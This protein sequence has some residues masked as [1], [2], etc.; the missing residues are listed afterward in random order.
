MPVY[1]GEKYLTGAIESI[2]RQSFSDFEFIIVNDGSTDTT[3]A[4][5]GSFND[6]RIVYIKN[7]ENHGLV[8]SLNTGIKATRG[9]YIARMDADDISLSGRLQRQLDFLRAHPDVDI[10]GSAMKRIDAY[11]RPSALL[12]RPT[13]HLD[14]KWASLFSTPMFHPTVMAK[15]SVFK[16]NLFDAELH[17]SEDYELWSRL[18][19][20][21][22]TKFA[23]IS[24][25]LLNYRVYSNSFTQGL[26]TN[27]RI[28]SAENSIKNIAYYTNVSEQEKAALILIRQEKP[29]SVRQSSL[30]LTMYKRAAKGFCAKEHLSFSQSLSVRSKLLSYAFFL[31]K[32]RVKHSLSQR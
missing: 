4:I 25:P 7:N 12:H 3:D 2:L 24:E 15:A 30:V 23:N 13:K 6:S 19:F 9:Q 27:K 8:S 10:V 22:P 26:D 29:I 20:T 32:Y 18:L 31:L 5:V 14:I 11:D 1:N 28:A 21:T 16:D 17:N